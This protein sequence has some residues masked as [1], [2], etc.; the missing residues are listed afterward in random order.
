MSVTAIPPQPEAAADTGSSRRRWVVLAAVL[1][2]VAVAGYLYLDR[3]NAPEG[4]VPGEVVTLEPI[5]VNLAA[6]H[7]LKLG[8]AVQTTE[9]ATDLEGSKAL[10][11]AITM[12]SGR[13]VA[14]LT[15]ATQREAL[16]ERLVDR[17]AELYDDQVMG[18][19]FTEFVMQ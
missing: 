3:S 17:L 9:E 1:A 10:D 14:E 7:Y 2:I 4:P 8:L 16:K 11:A 15:D 18:V 12:F 5:Q 6:G 13:S 19:Y